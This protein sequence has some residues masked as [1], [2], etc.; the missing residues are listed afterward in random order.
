MSR[1]TRSV[2][3]ARQVLEVL[4]GKILDKDL[5]EAR[6]ALEGYFEALEAE[7]KGRYQAGYMAAQRSSVRSP[8]ATAR[9]PRR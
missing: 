3:W 4:D 8:M 6:E 7:W 1:P 2:A 5:P 9:A